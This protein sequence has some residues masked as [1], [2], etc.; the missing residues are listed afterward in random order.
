MWT[1]R[2]TKK[3]DKELANAPAEIQQA[4]DAWTT[5]V[6]ESGPSA[7]RLINGYWDH[8]L[9]GEWEGARASSLN[10]QWRVIYIVESDTVTVDVVRVSAHNY[11]R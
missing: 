4:F 9:K 6:T 7:L 2:V 11:R 8:A 3:A 5:L 10:K 1:I